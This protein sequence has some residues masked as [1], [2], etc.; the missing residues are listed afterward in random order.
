VLDEPCLLVGVQLRTR[1]SLRV[2]GC[3]T[4]ESVRFACGIPSE[5]LGD[6]HLRDAHAEG[7]LSDGCVASEWG[8]GLEAF[9]E[10]DV[11]FLFVACIEFF[12][13]VFSV[14]SEFSFARRYSCCVE[15]TQGYTL[16]VN[17]ARAI[18]ITLYHVFAETHQASR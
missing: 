3:A 2:P 8:E 15:G 18:G 11:A 4:D 6:G 13:S 5:P 9:G 1:R 12:G 10:M 14:H 7:D 17:S 16:L